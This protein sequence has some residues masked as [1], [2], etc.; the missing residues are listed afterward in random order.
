MLQAMMG[1]VGAAKKDKP[2]L[3]PE[4]MAQVME[5]FRKFITGMMKYTYTPEEMA[6]FG[7]M[8]MGGMKQ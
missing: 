3:P 4:V 5:G 7:E 8:M 2:A 6:K 1:N